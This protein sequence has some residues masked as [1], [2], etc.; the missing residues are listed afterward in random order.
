MGSSFRDNLL[1]VFFVIY[2]SQVCRN[3][4]IGIFLSEEEKKGS[5][6]MGHTR[7]MSMQRCFFF[8]SVEKENY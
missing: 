8:F 5:V 7:A 1:I 2:I 3:N 6:E 4:K